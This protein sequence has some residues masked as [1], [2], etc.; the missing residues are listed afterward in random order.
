MPSALRLPGN[1]TGK[2][3]TF[4][5]PRDTTDNTEV[6]SFLVS[7]VA[8]RGYFLAKEAKTEQ[9]SVGRR[10]PLCRGVN[11]AEDPLKHCSHTGLHTSAVSLIKQSKTVKTVNYKGLW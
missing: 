2:T 1:K 4:G 5:H 9:N 8:L 10:D 11:A 7:K 6:T 3:D